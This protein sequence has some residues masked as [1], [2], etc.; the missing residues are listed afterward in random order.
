MLDRVRQVK[1][2]DRW[3]SGDGR[4]IAVLRF[5]PEFLKRRYGLTFEESND[6]LDF[7]ELA[8]IELG[9]GQ[10]VWLMRYRNAPGPG[11]VVYADSTVDP[12]QTRAKLIEGLGLSLEDLNWQ[13]SDDETSYRRDP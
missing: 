1:P 12:A 11:T 4:P 2:S 8:A 5:E 13:R 10:Q 7:Y 9:D 3:P 6:D